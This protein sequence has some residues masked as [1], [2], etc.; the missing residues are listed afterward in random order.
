ME[1]F[2]SI[3]TDKPQRT[4][5][6]EH[7]PKDLTLIALTVAAIIVSAATDRRKTV[8]GARRGWRMLMNLLPQFLLL[9]IFVSVFIT[10]VP[11]ETLAAV[12]GRRGCSLGVIAAAMDTETCG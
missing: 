8:Q 10:L 2:P 11:P 12:L 1:N 7:M 3:D 6:G 9:L 4:R 5:P